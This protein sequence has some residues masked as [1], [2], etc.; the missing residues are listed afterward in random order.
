MGKHYFYACFFIN[1]K[2]LRAINSIL[3]APNLINGFDC[4]KNNT[5]K[6]F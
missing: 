6:N 5:I 1:I 2:A 4:S 3:Y